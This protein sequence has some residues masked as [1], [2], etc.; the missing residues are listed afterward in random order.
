M[1]VRTSRIPALPSGL[2]HARAPKPAPITAAASAGVSASAG[3]HVSS[4][5][6]QSKSRRRQREARYR[7]AVAHARKARDP[8][9]D[10]GCVARDRPPRARGFIARI[11]VGIGLLIPHSVVHR[12][13]V[14][15][16]I[17]LPLR[18][19]LRATERQVDATVS[20]ITVSWDPVYILVLATVLHHQD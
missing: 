15:L 3:A 10:T 19:L 7:V 14:P 20:H 4:G 2:R 12:L 8:P 16:V 9:G 5:T 17:R 11:L 1:V 13:P 6:P 18:P